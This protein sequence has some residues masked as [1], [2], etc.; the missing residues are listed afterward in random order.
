MTLPTFRLFLF[1]RSLILAKLVVHWHT[2]MFFVFGLTVTTLMIVL[3]T[4]VCLK[5]ISEVGSALRVIGFRSLLSDLSRVW[6][7]LLSVELLLLSILVAYQAIQIIVTLFLSALGHLRLYELL[8]LLIILNILWQ[9]LSKIILQVFTSLASFNPFEGS[10]WRSHILSLW[11]SLGRSV[12]IHS[13]SLVLLSEVCSIMGCIVL[14][15]VH[16]LFF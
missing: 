9:Q 14:R 10:W 3:L 8:T 6:F 15:H 1:K 7:H 12:L 13:K 11:I 4:I 5:S 2:L 16:W